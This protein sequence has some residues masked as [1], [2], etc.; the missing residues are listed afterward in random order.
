MSFHLLKNGSYVHLYNGTFYEAV[1][2]PSALS[3]SISYRSKAEM[4][5]G[6]WVRFCNLN[7]RDTKSILWKRTKEK[8]KM[9]NLQYSTDHSHR[10]TS[11]RNHHHHNHHH[12]LLH[13]HRHRHQIHPVHGNH[14]DDALQ[15]IS[16]S[17]Q[18]RWNTI[19]KLPIYRI[20]Y[21]IMSLL[22]ST[23]GKIP[24]MLM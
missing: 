2:W 3:H 13:S 6:I 16:Q 10:G 8:W 24:N 9:I 21:C 22:F 1:I 18:W 4:S 19:H 14:Q 23:Q 7:L 20:S 5:P 17:Q 11:L 15:V 12:N